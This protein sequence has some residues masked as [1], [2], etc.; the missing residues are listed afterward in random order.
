MN[1]SAVIELLRHL[2]AIPSVNPE[3]ADDDAIRGEKRLADW[4]EPWFAAKGFSTRR[5][6][7]TAGRP[8]V[9]AQL[10]PDKPA[11]TLMFESHLDTVGVTGYE[12]NPFELREVDGKLYGR[13]SCD[14]KGPLA[15][16][17]AA[18]DDETLSALGK[19]GTQLIWLGAIGEETGNY[20]AEEAV[21]AGIRADECVVLEP[22]GLQ[23]V[24]AH[25]G[26][27]WFKV[28]TRGRAA[29]GSDPTRGDN[30][31]FKMPAVWRAIEEAT[32]QAAT[33]FTMPDLGAPTVSLG[34][35]VGGTGTNIVPDHCEI[36]VD[37]RFLP[38]ESC[39]AI[40][41]DLRRR[42]ADIPGGAEFT[43]MKEGRAF[44]TAADAELP[45][46]L[47]AALAAAGVEPATVTAAWCSD[48]G[49]LAPV[50]GQTLVWGPG[51][52]AQAHTTAEFI[53]VESLQAGVETLR[54]FLRG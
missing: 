11:R 46:R 37:R 32:T 35:I 13:G 18:L 30:A 47:S 40:L 38:G 31:I 16:F 1:S 21:A 28:A 24:H 39:A 15:A 6:E 14:T 4:L 10:G 54:C 23:I 20:G 22:T 25:K 33:R 45:R 9:V 5:I 19:S 51:D 49:V 42:V 50:C 52:I 48:A 12:G 34:T 29:H 3:L 8:N 7:T 27:C 26:A 17:M 53:A 44:H 41:E 36:Q 43:L 2:V